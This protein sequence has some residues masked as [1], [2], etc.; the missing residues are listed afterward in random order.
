MISVDFATQAA[1]NPCESLM[2]DILHV[3]TNVHEGCEE[4][5]D[6]SSSVLGFKVYS[7]MTTL[8]SCIGYLIATI[9]WTNMTSVIIHEDNVKTKINPFFTL[10]QST[11]IV[12]TVLFVFTAMI[13]LSCARETPSRHLANKHGGSRDSLCN[14]EEQREHSSETCTAINLINP[15]SVFQNNHQTQP[16]K[17][18]FHSISFKF[19]CQPLLCIKYFSK[20]FFIGINLIAH[21]AVMALVY[22]YNIAM[23]LM[24]KV[25]NNYILE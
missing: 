20:L 22:L 16:S 2:A 14:L 17:I 7:Y 21:I 15:K 10:E 4:Y 6:L 8:G 9:D 23:T 11:F 1:I 19:F 12:V 25:R 24:N 5:N 18:N 3:T 13:T